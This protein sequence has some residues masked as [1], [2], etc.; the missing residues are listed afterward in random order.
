MQAQISLSS[1]MSFELR[2]A[3]LVYRS[4][5]DSSRTGPS[6]FVTKH[7]VKLN[8][9]G[10][11]SLDAGSPIHPL[12]ISA[13]IEQLR[14][15]LPVE[16]L[17]SNVL[18]RTQDSIVWWTSPTTR[19]MFYAK[20]KGAE[21]AQLSGLRFP[22]P[23]LIFRAQP[24]HL[25]IRAVS[26]KERPAPDTLLYRAPYWNVNDS[27]DVCLGSTRVP[28]Q[29]TVDS[30]ARWESGFFES[31]FTH[32]NAANKLTE[33]PGG[34]IGLWKSLVGKHKFPAEYLADAKETL[35]QFIQR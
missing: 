16:F 14:G 2:E 18:V 15:T 35:G 27:G 8:H 26:C 17:P 12:D 11:P 4:D 20:E 19:A 1:T 32:P 28:R 22:Q 7:N 9:A 21:V 10:V 13:L 29:V 23:G 33:H 6:A 34:F 24:G 25:S 30:L 3:L 5:H 31:E